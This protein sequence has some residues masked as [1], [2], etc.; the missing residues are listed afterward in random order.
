LNLALKIVADQGAKLGL[1]RSTLHERLD[2]ML[3][4]VDFPS[5]PI[6]GLRS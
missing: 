5:S 4:D 2:A 3:D 6:K 1:A